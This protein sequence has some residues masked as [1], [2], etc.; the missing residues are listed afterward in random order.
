MGEIYLG[1]MMKDIIFAFKCR[2]MIPLTAQMLIET[3]KLLESKLDAFSVILN[4]ARRGEMGLTLDEDKTPEWKEAKNQYAIH[5]KQYQQVN[6]RLSKLRKFKGY[7]I[8]D[9]K[10]IATYQYK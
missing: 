10:R 5:W 3:Q 4:K 6:S 8:I 2:Y 1:G 7:Q 9:G